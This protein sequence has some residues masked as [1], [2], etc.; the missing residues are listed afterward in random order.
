MES[1]VPFFRVMVINP[2]A[3]S[4][5][6]LASWYCG[7]DSSKGNNTWSIAGCDFKNSNTFLLV[8]V[9]LSN[10]AGN[11]LNPRNNNQALNGDIPLPTFRYSESNILLIIE[12]EPDNTPPKVSLCPL[13][14]FVAVCMLRST[15]NAIGL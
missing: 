10:L 2:Q 3:P 13:I 14:Y 4:I 8:W 5:C 15:P 6:S 1:I 12:W 11:V 7:N 9:I